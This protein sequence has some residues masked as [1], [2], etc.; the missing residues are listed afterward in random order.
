MSYDFNE[1]AKT[2]AER[3]IDRYH[4]HLRKIKIAYVFKGDE[5]DAVP[6]PAKDGKSITYAKASL[7]PEKYQ[8]IADD[9]YQFMIEFSRPIWDR[10][11]LKHQE[12]LVDHELCVPAGVMVAGPEVQ[13]SIARRY[14]GE[15]VAIRT[16]S[17][18]FLPATP[19]HPV[20]SQRGWV[21]IGL[22]K[23]GD[24]VLSSADPER[25]AAA[26]DPHKHQVEARIED[27]ARP[28]NVPFRFVPE[29]THDLNGR[30]S[31]NK[32]DI[33]SADRHLV[34]YLTSR[35]A[36][37]IRKVYFG[38]RNRIEIHL[39][40]LSELT[41]RFVSMP[42]TAPSVMGGGGQF[43]PFSVT[44]LTE[45]VFL[46]GTQSTQ[47]NTPLFQNVRENAPVGAEMLSERM[48]RCPGGVTLDEIVSVN[49]RSFS[50]HVY[51]LQTSQN[52]SSAN[53]IITHNCHC[54]VHRE[55]GAVYTRDHSLEEFTEILRR[56]GMW[57]ESIR[58]FLEAGQPLFDQPGMQM[59]LHSELARTPAIAS[60]EPVRIVETDEMWIHDVKTRRWLPVIPER[61]EVRC[62]DGCDGPMLVRLNNSDECLQ[63]TF[64]PDLDNLDDFPRWGCATCRK[65][66]NADMVAAV[67][68]LQKMQGVGR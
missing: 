65:T 9:D 10:L 40:G 1:A 13:A 12:A 29:T 17:G 55:T 15:I 6:V 47:L 5:N 36:E 38:W 67:L 26:M 48:Q 61:A 7:V 56:H 39:S 25:M 51:N 66:W 68:S 53:H 49:V 64:A 30:M 43:V 63:Q 16:A 27:V 33:V 3:Y 35:A 18:Y 52:W 34:A 58:H 2:I 62:I 11:E 4:P 59:N 50:G 20:L 44:H 46:R 14:S 28:G 60:G 57:R 22:L 37:H 31:H 42:L 19:N 21:P 54:G 8:L 32:I 23:K 24:Y 45:P 41:H